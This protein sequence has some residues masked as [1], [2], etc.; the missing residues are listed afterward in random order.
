MAR[1]LKRCAVIHFRLAI[2]GMTLSCATTLFAGNSNVTS[3]TP[4]LPHSRFF[5]C[6]KVV[7]EGAKSIFGADQHWAWKMTYQDFRRMTPGVLL[8]R[9][10]FAIRKDYAQIGAGLS[11]QEAQS[12]SQYLTNE[13]LWEDPFTLSVFL[14]DRFGN[15]QN[16]AYYSALS[17]A[18]NLREGL[19]LLHAYDKARGTE[20]SAPILLSIASRN[21]Q[22]LFGLFDLIDL[23]K[24][25]PSKTLRAHLLKRFAGSEFFWSE[26]E[27]GA[28][29]SVDRF[30]GEL[31]ELLKGMQDGAD[32]LVE[33]R[34]LNQILTRLIVREVDLWKSDFG[35]HSEL[36]SRFLKIGTEFF[37]LADNTKVSSAYRQ[38]ALV[39]ETYLQEDHNR[40][41]RGLFAPD[42]PV[43][44]GKYNSFQEFYRALLDKI[45]ELDPRG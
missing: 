9:T 31:P 44:T 8:A 25:H 40:T 10:S 19:I 11:Q 15:Y 35:N 39:F 24:S 41:M 30:S 34:V 7:V 42:L 32:E 33:T 12:L 21:G 45:I 4:S 14:N 20:L 23:A 13:S 16:R 43:P 18:D 28:S 3:D 1:F 37:R 38:A 26:L 36:A 22:R 2:I 6:W 17:V 27:E 29:E 5:R